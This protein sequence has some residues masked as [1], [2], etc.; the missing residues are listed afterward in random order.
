MKKAE[1]TGVGESNANSKWGRA[2]AA[3][4]SYECRPPGRRQK[5]GRRGR[6]MVPSA[7]EVKKI[8]KQTL[9][10]CDAIGKKQK[11]S[12]GREKG[13]VRSVGEEC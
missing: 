2:A 13:S 12:K 7:R 5:G 8:E 9:V 6:E 10:E 1:G 11:C 3:R 4:N